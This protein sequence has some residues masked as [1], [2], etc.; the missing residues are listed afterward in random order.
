[1]GKKYRSVGGVEYELVGIHPDG[2]LIIDH[3][4]SLYY[5]TPNGKGYLLGGSADLINDDP[6][7]E[8]RALMCKIRASTDLGLVKIIRELRGE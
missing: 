2:R 6:T 5:R 3:N 4:G 7:K 8:E 1:M